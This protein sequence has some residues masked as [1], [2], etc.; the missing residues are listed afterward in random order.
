M[1]EV[2]PRERVRV[3]GFPA[4]G[5][6]SRYHERTAPGR[7][8]KRAPSPQ[9]QRRCVYLL[10]FEPVEGSS[11]FISFVDEQAEPRYRYVPAPP[12]V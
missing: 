9:A 4:P 10:V 11:D 7:R 1:R 2:T 3:P 8:V 12:R 5:G 6:G